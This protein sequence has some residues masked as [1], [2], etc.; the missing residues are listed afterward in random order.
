M[1]REALCN[2]VLCVE[3][4]PEAASRFLPQILESSWGLGLSQQFAFLL[5]FVVLLHLGL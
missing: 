5:G 4:P 2:E 3:Q 1:D